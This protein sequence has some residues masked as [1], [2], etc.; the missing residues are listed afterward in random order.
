[1]TAMANW[2]SGK[3]KLFCQVYFFAKMW[4]FFGGIKS[5]QGCSGPGVAVV[6]AGLPACKHSSLITVA[7]AAKN[8][9]LDIL[10]G[11]VLRA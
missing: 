1:M 3:T 8:S 11:I 5:L 9:K 2:E 4:E 6:Q 7:L 10:N